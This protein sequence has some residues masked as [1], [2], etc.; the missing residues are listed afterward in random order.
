[1][2][3]ILPPEIG[4]EWSFVFL[5][6]YGDYLSDPP[7]PWHLVHEYTQDYDYLLAAGWPAGLFADLSIAR[8]RALTLAALP[9]VATDLCPFTHNSFFLGLFGPSV[10]RWNIYHGE[11]SEPLIPCIYWDVLADDPPPGFSWT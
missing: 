5:G 11:R 2:V 9:Q 4:P 6:H 7:K 1:M 3:K 10:P 8:L